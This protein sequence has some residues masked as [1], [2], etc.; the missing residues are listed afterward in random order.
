MYQEIHQERCKAEF[1]YTA[2][3]VHHERHSRSVAKAITWKL[4]ATAMAFVVSYGYTRDISSSASVALTMFV[5]GIVA[6][7]IHERVWNRISWGKG[8]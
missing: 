8:E 2:L 5:A 6:Y 7:Y 3:V 1:C 4:V